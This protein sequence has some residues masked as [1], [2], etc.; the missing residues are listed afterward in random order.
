[1]SFYTSRLFNQMFPLIHSFIFAYLTLPQYHFII[2][3][4]V[5]CS[6]LPFSTSFSLSFIFVLP[7]YTHCIHDITF[8]SPWPSFT[9]LCYPFHMLLSTKPTYFISCPSFC[10][11]QTRLGYI[12]NIWMETWSCMCDIKKINGCA[13]YIY[14]KGIDCKK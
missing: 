13:T 4:T 2:L 5:T 1:M 14:C 12:H 10:F 7:I 3:S 8:I 9:I 6:H 11:N